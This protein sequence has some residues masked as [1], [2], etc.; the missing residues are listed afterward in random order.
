MKESEGLTF[1]FHAD[2]KALL[3]ATVRTSFALRFVNVTGSIGHTRVGFLVLHRPFEESFTRLARQQA[4][5]VA[6]YFVAAHRTQF[7]NA[8]FRVG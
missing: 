8:F 7:F 6:G 4:V 2:F 5:M 1:E 3:E